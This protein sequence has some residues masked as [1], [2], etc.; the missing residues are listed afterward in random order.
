MGKRLSGTCYIKVDGVQLEVEGSVEVPMSPHKR[1]SK[2]AL[3]GCAGYDERAAEPFVK[4]SVYLTSDF[5]LSTVTNGTDM[6][7][8]AELANGMTYVLSGAWL[9]DAPSVKADDGKAELYFGGIRG[10]FQ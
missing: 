8:T 3:T 6:T 1:E 4:A 7:V 5:P 10:E 2:M 9:N